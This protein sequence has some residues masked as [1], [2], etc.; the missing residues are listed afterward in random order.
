MSVASRQKLHSLV[1]LG[2]AAAFQWFFMFTKHNPVLRSIIPF[3]NDPYD[4]LGSFTTIV[5]ILLCLLLLWRSFRPMRGRESSQ[6]QSQHLRRTQAAIPLSIL[7]TIAAYAIA[8]VRHT[9][10][11]FGAPGQDKLLAVLAT[12]LAVS[13]AALSMVRFS[14]SAPTAPQQRERTAPSPLIVAALFVAML[15][16]YPEHLINRL[17]THLLTVLLGDLFLFVPVAAFLRFLFPDPQLAPHEQSNSPGVG[18]YA[19]IGAMLISLLIGVGLFVAEMTEGGAG[20]PP[21][22]KRLFVASVYIGL[23]MT[24]TLI[25]LAVLGRLLG[26]RNGTAAQ[27]SAKQ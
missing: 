11:W 18:R 19:W 8:M 7:V 12:M 26:L 9:N 15:G 21:I 6:A 5:N 27:P 14:V 2:V 20:I 22:R 16:F 23:T 10:L 25:A 3:G 4:A 13:A 1:I 17:S 24:G